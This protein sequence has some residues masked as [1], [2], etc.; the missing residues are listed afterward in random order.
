MPIAD[1]IEEVI[2]RILE[3]TQ[4]IPSPYNVLIFLFL[5]TLLIAIYAIFV[6]NFYQFI[7][8][9]NIIELNL[10]QYNKTERPFF[11]KVLASTLYLIE[12]VFILPFIIF[13]VF[14]VFSGILLILAAT[15]QNI[16]QILLIAAAVIATIRMTAYYRRDLAKDLAKMF[17]LMI[18]TIFLITPNFFNPD[19]IIGQI[20]KISEL[21]GNIFYYLV[22][23]IGLELV[24]RGFDLI[25]SLFTGEDNSEQVEM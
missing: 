7:S 11:N 8:K 24:L 19:R 5:F 13:F 1:F 14:I 25:I 4:Q 21:T 16:D 23:I 10:N 22:F 20:S 18:L 17:P 15:E 2:I 6:W 3:L 9:K 12:Y